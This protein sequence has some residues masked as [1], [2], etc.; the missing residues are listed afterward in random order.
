MS[1]Q[2]K[3]GSDP[4]TEKRPKP[5]SRYMGPRPP[6]YAT[7]TRIPFV[8]ATDPWTPRHPVAPRFSTPATGAGRYP[9]TVPDDDMSAY[10]ADYKRRASEYS[11]QMGAPGPSPIN[12]RF[13]GVTPIPPVPRAHG[14]AATGYAP[15]G[16]GPL[17]RPSDF[18][19]DALYNLEGTR[20]YGDRSGFGHST[21]RSERKRPATHPSHNP[22]PIEEEEEEMPVD[23]NDMT[24]QQEDA[25]SILQEEDQPPPEDMENDH[26]KS[27]TKRPK[28]QSKQEKTESTKPANKQPSTSTQ[29]EQRQDPPDPPKR[30]PSKVD[31]W[32]A[33]Y[34]QY[35]EQDELGQDYYEMTPAA[36]NARFDNLRENHLIEKLAY[37]QQNLQLMNELST[38]HNTT[39]IL[40]RQLEDLRHQLANIAL[41]RQG[42]IN[43][44]Q[45][46]VN[47]S[48]QENIPPPDG[49]SN[50]VPPPNDYGLS[51]PF[52]G[53]RPPARTLNPK[54][55]FCPATDN[56]DQFLDD[57]NGYCKWNSW[58][59][60]NKG[61]QLRMCLDRSAAAML[62]GAPE[63]LK[64]NYD[65][66]VQQLYSRFDP[67]K[68]E[69]Q[70]VIKFDQRKHDS[71]E[72]VSKLAEDLRILALQ[73]FP[74][75]TA[76]SKDWNRTMCLKLRAIMT[77]ENLKQTVAALSNDD[78]EEMV[79][80]LMNCE[81][82]FQTVKANKHKSSHKDDHEKTETKSESTTKNDDKSSE[83]PPKKKSKTSPTTMP[84]DDDSDDDETATINA[85]GTPLACFYCRQTGHF[86]RNCPLRLARQP[87]AAPLTWP[88]QVPN[89]QQYQ[90][91]PQG[92]APS[93]QGYTPFNNQQ[94]QWPRQQ[95]NAWSQQQGSWPQQPTPYQAQG[96]WPSQ[97][98]PFQPRG[99]GPYMPRPRWFRRPKNP[100][101]AG[102]NY[103]QNNKSGA[104]SANQP[105]AQNNNSQVPATS[106]S[107]AV[108]PYV[109][110]AS[111]EEDTTWQEDQDE[112]FMQDPWGNTYDV[113]GNQ[114]PDP[115]GIYFNLFCSSKLNEARRAYRAMQANHQAA[116]AQP[117]HNIST[118]EEAAENLSTLTITELPVEEQETSS[119]DKK[120]DKG[121]PAT[122]SPA[123]TDTAET[124]QKIVTD[125]SDEQKDLI[126][127]SIRNTTQELEDIAPTT[128]TKEAWE[129]LK[130]DLIQSAAQALKK[131]GA[132][133]VTGQPI[134]E[135]A[136]KIFQHQLNDVAYNE[137][138]KLG[139]L[140]YVAFG[141]A[142]IDYH[143]MVDSGCNKSVIH[144]D[145]YDGLPVKPVLRPAG[146]ATLEN[147]SS[148]RV[149][150]ECTVTLRL[151]RRRF[152]E[153]NI[154]VADLTNHLAI[155]GLD[156]L[157]SLEAVPD[158]NRGVLRM[159]TGNL[160]MKKL[161]CAMSINYIHCAET[162]WVPSNSEYVVDGVADIDCKGVP[163]DALVERC[164]RQV[165]DDVTIGNTLVKA[166]GPTVPVHVMNTNPHPVRLKQGDIIASMSSCEDMS[167]VETLQPQPQSPKK[168]WSTTQDYK[169]TRPSAEQEE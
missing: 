127:Q 21:I 60:T 54:I 42:A 3:S 81:L 138:K 162:T 91:R 50:N 53:R 152:V 135:H 119:S 146:N 103:Q 14:Y 45:P 102:N 139:Q 24:S 48:N 30:R 56:L 19:M 117:M 110:S 25:S 159:P 65:Y 77:Q 161:P 126:T 39:Y 151:G 8:P 130:V 122:I 28:Q 40:T 90:Q 98:R 89:N 86:K 75:K 71:T 57:F 136:L 58:D 11:R 52:A 17:P 166:S 141:L 76:G 113:Y 147:G 101:Y 132:P 31:Q 16:L 140:W 59:D 41:E 105:T 23:P 55:T 134:D 124:E 2:Q 154:L 61:I 62:N 131:F 158:F 150:G 74:E 64:Y 145:V 157:Q 85:F 80:K 6:K 111:F 116:P 35:A 73:A 114:L 165:S 164:E 169:E 148:V 100:R 97:Y 106:Q 156:M 46:L 129:Q 1:Q 149:Y 20:S 26:L 142:N 137:S 107:Q 22:E 43:N 72:S 51:R 69:D 66:I 34:D 95:Y 18:D 36:F 13:G 96:Q 27:D 44:P 47:S 49:N 5:Q 32:Q 133:E 78:F 104:Q 167:E 4:T 67:R 118:P 109:H 15:P 33:E 115:D 68:K 83:P 160:F 84:E 143:F 9:H 7:N 128:F 99:Q 87:P 120:P 63:A 163:F 38:Q 112:Y 92:P 153:H 82:T 123:P 125:N 168:D 108:V 144:K 37:E 121:E 10:L 93:Q 12:F 79:T 94:G 88:Q 155:M 29:E 70:Y